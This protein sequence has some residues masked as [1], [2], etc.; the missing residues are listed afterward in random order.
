MKGV[1]ANYCKRC[2]VNIDEKETYYNKCI[3]VIKNEEK[4]KERMKNI[5]A[6]NFVEKSK[7]KFWGTLG[8][9][10]S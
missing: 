4:R 6:F 10:N 8:I 9:Q 3:I 7:I 2:L 5:I 1:M